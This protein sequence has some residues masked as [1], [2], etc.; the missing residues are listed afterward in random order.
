MAKDNTTILRE[1]LEKFSK[2]TIKPYLRDVLS[3]VAKRL[4]AVIDGEA[5]VPLPPYTYREAPERIGGNDQFPVWK[6]H[7][8]DATGLAVYIDGTILKYIPTAKAESTQS[9]DGINGIVGNTELQQAIAE[10]GSTFASGIW[11]VLF[12]SVP[13]AYEVNVEGSSWGRGVG[14]FDN[15]ENELLTDLYMNL[16]PVA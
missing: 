5:F 10:A 7:M 6:G 2:K 3:R 8:H 9:Y 4:V 14:Y 16:K 12:S 13:Y 1:G 11:I 15:L